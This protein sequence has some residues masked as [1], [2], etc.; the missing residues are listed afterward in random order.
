MRRCFRHRPRGRWRDRACAADDVHDRDGLGRPDARSAPSERH[1]DLP[2]PPTRVRELVCYDADLGLV[3]SLAASWQRIDGR[4]WE[5]ELRP[6]VVFHD[7]TPLRAAD[8]ARSLERLRDPAFAAPASFLLQMLETIDAVGDDVVRLTTGEPFA[9]LI[10]H[11]AHPAAA[12]VSAATLQ[13]REGGEAGA[14]PGTGPYHIERWDPATRLVL[15]RFDEWWGSPDGP[16]SLVFRPVPDPAV[17]AI[18]LEVGA[19]DIAFDLLAL[20]A[21]RLERRPSLR[22]ESVETLLTHDVGFN[23][24]KPPFDDPRVR[25]AIGHGLD[26]PG[27]VAAVYDGAATRARGPLPAGTFGAVDDLEPRPYDADRARAALRDAGFGD[28]LT[29]SLFTLP[30]PRMMAAA[31]IVQ[32]QL[33]DIGIDVRI[34]TSD[35]GAFLADT[36][37]GQHDLFI[38][39]WGT[40]TGDADYGLYAPFHSSQGGAGGNRSFY[41]NARVDVLLDLA[42]GSL[43]AHDRLAAYHEAQRI[44]HD[45]APW[46]YLARPIDLTAYRSE[47]T[48]FAPQPTMLHR[49]EALERR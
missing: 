48:G 19:A 18:E 42:R 32:A 3:P 38:L 1:G 20:D 47:I 21:A 5:F 10:N 33:A 8:V 29:A 2:G 15:R 23:T 9:P 25:R 49:L 22:V 41:A 46:I 4:T 11:L 31:E 30:D 40:V 37:A 14:L 13:G 35:A 45:D 39:G 43:H 27:L 44:I 34:V 16:T 36:A 17:P 12:I 28:R 6:G 24:C 26:L 7:G